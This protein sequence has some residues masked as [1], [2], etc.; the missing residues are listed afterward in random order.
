MKTFPD[1]AMALPAEAFLFG[2]S[3]IWALLVFL[4]CLYLRRE[5]RSLLAELVKL[6]ARVSKVNYEPVLKVSVEITPPEDVPPL[7]PPDR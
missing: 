4:A 2:K 5:I 1:F 7:Q 6:V 3:V